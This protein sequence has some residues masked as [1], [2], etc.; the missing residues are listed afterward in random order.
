MPRKISGDEEPLTAETLIDKAGTIAADS[1]QWVE[2]N[3]RNEPLKA[4]GV[5]MAAGYVLPKLPVFGVVG[6]LLRLLLILRGRSL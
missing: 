1:L 3:T 2:D 4:I 5:A 6:A